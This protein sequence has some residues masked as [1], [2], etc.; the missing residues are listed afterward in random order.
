M[1]KKIYYINVPFG[2]VPYSFYAIYDSMTLN[3]DISFQS[4]LY[5]LN[6]LY[7]QIK[8][9]KNNISFSFLYFYFAFYVFFLFFH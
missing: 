7:I 6:Y 3:K 9:D 4:I 1:I 2:G 8:I 5:L